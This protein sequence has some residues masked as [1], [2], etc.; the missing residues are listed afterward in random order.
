MRARNS[1]QSVAA[2]ALQ[3]PS[4]SKRFCCSAVKAERWSAYLISNAKR[5][6]IDARGSPLRSLVGWMLLSR[7]KTVTASSSLENYQPEKAVD[8]DIR[9]WWSAR[10]GD[11][12]EWLQ[13]D[14]GAAMRVD[15]LQ[16]NFAD[17]D[18]KGRGIS[19]DVFKYVIDASVDGQTWAA[20]I[21]MSSNG[22]DAPHDYRVL[23]NCRS[24]K[25]DAHGTMAGYC[26]PSFVGDGASASRVR[27]VGRLL[28]GGP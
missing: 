25:G 22:R 21:D 13:V 12:G 27:N 3:D 10:T 11:P 28:V 15:A 2:L 5:S 23:P 24:L 4:R 14:L 6:A 20:I 26:N 8:E 19:E 16:L 1:I 17:Q 18:S 9:T 7:H